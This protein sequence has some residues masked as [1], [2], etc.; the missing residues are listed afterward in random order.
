MKRKYICILQHD[1]M[2]CGATCIAMI[3]KY[4]GLKIPIGK[5][6][7]YASTNLV[8]T[9]VLGLKEAGE[10]LKFD[11]KAVRGEKKDFNKKLQTPFIAHIN[12]D[13]LLHYVV[14]YKITKDKVVIADPA[15]GLL[16]QKKR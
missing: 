2:D 3:S 12:K 14:V 5:I 10:K 16:K 15:E 8:G 13:G 4:Y 6:R 1:T 9:N 11:V 7:Q